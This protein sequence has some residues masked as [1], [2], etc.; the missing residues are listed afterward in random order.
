M[1]REREE[2]NKKTAKKKTTKCIIH[3]L[4]IRKT[5]ST[6]CAGHQINYFGNR[7][8]KLEKLNLL[9]SIVERNKDYTTK[10]L[11]GIRELFNPNFG[12]EMN[13]T[14][15]QSEFIQS[16][17]AQIQESQMNESEESILYE[18]IL[19]TKELKGYSE[20]SKI[21]QTQMEVN[22]DLKTI[23][24]EL[25]FMK[26]FHREETYLSTD[27]LEKITTYEKFIT[28]YFI[29]LTDISIEKILNGIIPTVEDIK[30]TLLKGLKTLITDLF[31]QHEFSNSTDM[32]TLINLKNFRKEKLNRL[33]EKMEESE[34]RWNLLGYLSKREQISYFILNYGPGNASNEFAKW[35]ELQNMVTATSMIASFLN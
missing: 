1:K 10:E 19:G 4:Q 16:E 32:N 12:T 15:I 33:K 3:L 7:D 6:D 21:T 18:D 35:E 11:I 34:K 17:P 24:R 9:K 14:S 13:K 2:D 31:L 22:L 23:E 30:W 29:Q 8:T 5:C 26:V 27:E 25:S 28:D 20:I